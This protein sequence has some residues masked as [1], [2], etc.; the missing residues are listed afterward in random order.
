LRDLHPLRDTSLPRYFSFFVV[1]TRSSLVLII[2]LG[3]VLGIADRTFENLFDAD[4][5]D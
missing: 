4:Y 3:V 1:L 5:I 2:G